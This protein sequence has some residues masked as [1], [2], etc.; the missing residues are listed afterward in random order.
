MNKRI[1]TNIQGSNLD[2]EII[3]YFEKTIINT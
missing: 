1:M 3:R 2:C